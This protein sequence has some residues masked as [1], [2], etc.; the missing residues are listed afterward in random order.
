MGSV[1]LAMDQT[2]IYPLDSP[3]V[4][5]IGRMPIP[6]LIKSVKTLFAFPLATRQVFMLS[7]PINIKNWQPHAS[8]NLPI[9][10]EKADKAAL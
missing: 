6:Y 10:P 8:I 5:L 4:E 2:V 1:G 7:M 3:E 9:C